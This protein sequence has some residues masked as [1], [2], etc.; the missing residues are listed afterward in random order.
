MYLYINIKIKYNIKINIG[1]VSILEV[2]ARGLVPSPFG[3]Y[4]SSVTTQ[5]ISYTS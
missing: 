5:N 1:R 3:S 2:G 4:C